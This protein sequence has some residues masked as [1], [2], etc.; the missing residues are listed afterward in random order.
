MK[1]TFVFYITKLSSLSSSY[2]C[3]IFILPRYDDEF[4]FTF[5]F[6]HYGDEFLFIFHICS[7]SFYFHF[8]PLLISH[9]YLRTKYIFQQLLYNCTDISNISKEL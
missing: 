1:K 8:C 7:L 3:H 2:F 9:S 5:I 4:L 6:A